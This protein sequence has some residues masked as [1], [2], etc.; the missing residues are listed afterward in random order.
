M[1]RSRGRGQRSGDAARASG[2]YRP[3][4]PDAV[5]VLRIAIGVRGDPES[6]A[7]RFR[8]VASEVAPTLQIH[9]LMPMDDA[10]REPVGGVSVPVA[11]AAGMSTIALLLSLTAIYSVMAFTVSRRTR[12]IGLRVALGADRR[13]VIGTILRRPLAQVGL[14]NV[15]GGILVA[16]TF[17]LIFESTPTAVEAAAIVAYAVVMMGMCLLACVVP[18]R[19]ALRSSQPA[20]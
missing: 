4:A 14:G 17:A 12:E 16:L 1:A 13:R 20:R 5:A 18:T 9:D 2:L 15:V 10:R 7:T 6:F 3:I 8:V 19:R 11:P